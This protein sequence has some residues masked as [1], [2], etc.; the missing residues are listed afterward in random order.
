MCDVLYYLQAWYRREMRRRPLMISTA[1]EGAGPR[2]RAGRRP[3]AAPRSPRT[4]PRAPDPPEPES[5]A[6][7]SD[8]SDEWVQ[9]APRAPRA[10]RSQRSQRS[11][12]DTQ[13]SSL[14]LTDSDSR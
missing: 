4:V 6:S 5:A 14:D 2:R 10:A 13:H 9:R 1:P 7:C 11:D 3:R 8:T 12:A